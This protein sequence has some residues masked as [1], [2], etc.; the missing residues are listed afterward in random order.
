MYIGNLQSLDDLQLHP[1]IA[2]I[3]RD[4]LATNADVLALSKG[5]TDLPLPAGFAFAPTVELPLF[6][7]VSEDMSEPAYNRRAEFHDEYADIQLLLSGEEWIGIGPHATEL[8][9]NDHPHPDLFFM[10]EAP[11]SYVA[12]QPGDFMVIMPGELHTPLCTL[13]DPAPLRKIVFKVH[14]SLLTHSA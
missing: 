11:L 5:K 3:L 1:V 7:V 9:R 8:Q 12:L 2:A 10:D 4:F 13:E 6:M 14:R